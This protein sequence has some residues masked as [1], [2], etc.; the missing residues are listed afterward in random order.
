M[1][2]QM[3]ILQLKLEHHQKR[4]VSIQTTTTTISYKWKDSNVTENYKKP[5][6]QVEQITVKK[7]LG[8]K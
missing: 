6:V 5:V 2:L 3:V 4:Q 7:K 8:G 1:H